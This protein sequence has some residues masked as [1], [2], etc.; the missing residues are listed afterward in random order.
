MN[1]Q[2]HDGNSP[3]LV[4][5]ANFRLATRLNKSIFRKAF[6]GEHT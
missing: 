6:M 4:A 1:T 5:T 2:V 3:E